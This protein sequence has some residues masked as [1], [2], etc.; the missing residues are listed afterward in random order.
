MVADIEILIPTKDRLE[1]LCQ[2]IDSILLQEGVSFIITI[3]DDASKDYIVEERIRELYPDISL[4]RFFK[5]KK[6]LGVNYARNETLRV[7]IC[8]YLLCLD[9]DVVLTSEDTLKKIVSFFDENTNTAVISPKLWDPQED[10][11]CV[12]F[13][14][15]L[16]WLD[17]ERIEKRSLVSYYHGAMFGM[18]RSCLDRVG[19]FS[20]GT[21]YN[22]HELD[23]SYRIIEAGYEIYYVP[24]IFGEH[25]GFHFRFGRNLPYDTLME[26][27]FLLAYKYLPFFYAVSYVSIWFLFYLMLVVERRKEMTSQYVKHFVSVV[28]KG[29]HLHERKP[30]GGDALKYLRSNSGR[31]WY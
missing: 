1:H 3:F 20:L 14:K 30:L 22:D 12:P 6:S 11:F 28:T 24:D 18:R 16:I 26:N 27:R 31:L 10:L 2:C 23:F 8:P 13:S 21:R 29:R 9:D 25:R 15:Y 17:P 5:S 7:S 19:L 4:F